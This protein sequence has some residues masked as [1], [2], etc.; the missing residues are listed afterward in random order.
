MTASE[1][2]YQGVVHFSSSDPKAILPPDQVFSG[3]SGQ[4]TFTVTLNTAGTQS[5]TIA[6]AGL[7]STKAKSNTLSVNAASAV[8]FAI[9]AASGPIIS[10][11]PHSYTVTAIDQNG[12]PTSFN[13]TVA[14]SDGVDITTPLAVKLI[15]GVGTFSV[16]LNALDIHVLDVGAGSVV[17]AQ[18]VFVAAHLVISGL[19]RAVGVEQPVTV[20]IT[21]KNA[22]NQVIQNVFFDQI[23][24]NISGGH[25][26]RFNSFV[27][28]SESVTVAFDTVGS[29]TVTASNY[30][31]PGAFGQAKTSVTPGAVKTFQVEFRPRT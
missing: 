11:A 18:P 9:S 8:G 12:D 2:N 28:G 16:P 26:V 31:A 3:T 30:G 27:N 7:A 6:D 10:G 25:I 17:G 29:Q 21:P 20:L 4:E 14:V 1:T 22:A 23:D 5:V 15:K 24:L 13:G 19:P